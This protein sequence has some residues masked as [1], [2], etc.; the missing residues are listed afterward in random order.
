MTEQELK[1]I[2]NRLLALTKARAIQWRKTGGSEYTV[3]FSRSS[4]VIETDW[5][6]VEPVIVMKVFNEDGLLVAYASNKDLAK[7]EAI[8]YFDFDPSEL[9][10]LVQ[11]QV[12]RYSE[13]SQNILDEL[14]GLEEEQERKLKLSDKEQ[15]RLNDIMRQIDEKISEVFDAEYKPDESPLAVSFSINCPKG[16]LTPAMFDRLE[17]HYKGQGW[18]RLLLYKHPANPPDQY[19]GIQIDK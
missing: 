4:I 10:N 7:D 19:Y 17:D 18:S 14:K 9:F 13:T 12:Y 8:M 16:E 3:S 1:E 11:A 6:Y 15:R 2:Y 5:N